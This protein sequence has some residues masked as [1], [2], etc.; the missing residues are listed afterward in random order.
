[1]PLLD[2]RRGE[3]FAAAYDHSGR[4][5]Q[6]PR[7]LPRESAL[8]ILTAELGEG[9]LLL[10]EVAA[11]LGG[12][13]HGSELSRLPDAV[14]A[15]LLASDRAPDQSIVEP[16]YVRDAGATPQALPPSPFGR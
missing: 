1:V 5:L 3:V 2:A 7:A 13:P 9:L 15:A 16:L 8:E 11:E 14:G 10:G 6:P 4:E 12:T